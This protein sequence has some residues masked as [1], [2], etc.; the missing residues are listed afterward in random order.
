MPFHSHHPQGP[1]TSQHGAASGIYQA[2][3]ALG[4]IGAPHGNLRTATSGQT[5]AGTDALLPGS[6]NSPGF[7][8]VRGAPPSAPPAIG[9]LPGPGMSSMAAQSSQTYPASAMQTPRRTSTLRQPEELHITPGSSAAGHQASSQSQQQQMYNSP[10]TYSAGTSAPNINLQQATPQGSTFTTSQPP[11]AANVP[12]SLQPGGSGSARPA[13]PYSANTAPTTVP[14]VPQINTNA[15]Q[16]TLPTRSNTMNQGHS[17]SRSS[18][19][20]LEQKYIPFNSQTPDNKSTF[21]QTPS[22]QKYYSPSTPQ[23]PAAHSPLD[24]KDIRPMGNIHFESM[25]ESTGAGTNFVDMEKQPGN[26]SYLAPWGVYAYDWCKWPIHNGNS[27]GK[28]AVG[29]YLEDTHNFVRLTIGQLAHVMADSDR[30]KF[31]IRMLHLRKL[32]TPVPRRTASNTQ[33]SQ[34]R[35]A[36]TLSHAYSGN[37]HPLRSNPLISLQHPATTYVYGRYHSLLL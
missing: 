24:L 26:C 4:S 8:D 17:Y 25:G 35:L 14:T 31:L 19:A 11:A 33:R 13:L 23:G 6:G 18:P 2:A 7:A 12:G 3:Q 9:G 30:F 15:Q 16:Y 5:G 22:G 34:K 32:P 28:M 27:A 20:G 21:A 29:S 37:R 1:N 10:D 36:L